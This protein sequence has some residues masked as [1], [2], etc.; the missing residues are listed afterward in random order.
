MGRKTVYNS[1]V[2][3]D[4]YSQVSKENKELIAEFLEYLR[5]TDKSPQTISQYEN[6]AKIFFVWNLQFNNNKFFVELGKRDVMKYQNYLLNELKQS[7]SRIRRLK[8][9]IS[10][11]SNFIESM[12]DDLYP[13]FRNIINK[14]PAPAKQSVREKTVLTE[15]QVEFLLN[16]LV[17]NKRYQQACAFALGIASGARKSE[18]LRYKVSFFKDEYIKYGAL[19]KTPETIKTKGRAKGKFI[20]KYTLVNKFKPYFELWMNERKELGIESDILFIKKGEGEII[21]ADISTLASWASVFSKILST[22]FY[23]HSLRHYFTT[24][25]VKNNIPADVI[26][27]IVGW[28]NLEMVSL[29]T[30]LSVDD[31]LGKYFSEDGIKKVEQKTIADI[32]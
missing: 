26:K 2:S 15:E 14:V 8:A 32:D 19:Y 24:E 17:E 28:E 23:W 12:M 10:S 25:L 31:S 1:I 18:L 20:Y 11:M 6:D 7:S 22:D 4:L 13:T 5:S 27:D 30:D 21:P 9:T 29:Y 3:T 16:Y